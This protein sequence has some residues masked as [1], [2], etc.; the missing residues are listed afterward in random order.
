M[1]PTL[2]GLLR[3]RAVYNAHWQIAAYSFT[4]REL[5]HHEHQGE[6]YSHDEVLLCEIERLLEAQTMSSGIW[7]GV[8]WKNLPLLSQHHFNG[9]TAIT[10]IAHGEPDWTSLDINAVLGD[11]SASYSIGATAK[12]WHLSQPQLGERLALIELN[13]QS[14]DFAVLSQQVNECRKIAPNAQLWVNDIDSREAAEA[15]FQLGADYVSGRV[16]N[17]P[18]AQQLSFPDS[19]LRL[20]QVLNLVR[21][22]TDAKIIAAELKSDPAL[23]A[24]L[25]RYVNSAALGLAQPISNLDQ[26]IVV[27]G[28]Q[29]LYRWLSLLLF[30]CKGDQELD[31]TLLETALTRARLMELA[32]ATRFSAS[33]CELLFLTGLFSLLDFLL[34]VPRSLLLAELNP[35]ATIS[36]TLQDKATAFTP[37]LQLA[38]CSELG[39]PPE[40]LLAQCQLD[41]AEFNR[42]Q[43]DASLWALSA[44]AS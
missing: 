24:R 41:S 1:P 29:R 7:L 44:L 36:D 15:C 18:Q 19:F 35:P 33:E 37:Y 34:R 20:N 28:N 22:N 10:I 43:I 11:L 42:I 2:P 26:A 13:V 14:P 3:R 40:D 9:S 21:Q 30:S 12:R 38:E 6:E 5:S 23:S 31:Q 32:A 25:L 17:W 4:L 39:W 8:H 16:F 27:V